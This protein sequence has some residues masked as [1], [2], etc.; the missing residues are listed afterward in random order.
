MA[1]RRRGSESIRE[2]AVNTLLA[3]LLRGSGV[4]AKA[5]RRSRRGTPDI[6]VDLRNGDSILLE[7][8]WVGSD[9]ALN[10]Q[11]D[12]RLKNFPEALGMFGV[13]YPDRIKH[14]ENAHSE[15]GAATDIQWWL[16]GS[17]GKAVSDRQVR[18]GTAADL[19]D[20][21]RALPLDLEGVD[22][23]VAAAAVVGYA[24][25][26][27]AGDLAQHKRISRR[28]AE[29]IAKT[30]R[31]KDRAAALRIGCL[32]LFNAIA[33][34]DRLAAVNSDVPT[35]PESWSQGVSRTARRLE[36]HL[37]QH[38]LRACVRVGG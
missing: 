4:S 32:V 33:F 2:E 6:R 23:V 10:S 17:R 18:R 12:D 29:I 13:L 11:L 16:Y 31:E 8:K 28:I 35:I 3:Q 36:K 14:A 25:E 9:S 20:Q 24:L 22:R 19:A 15:I 7:C 5:E 37:R 21:I 30:D 34:Q 1:A 38:R 26:Q 27:A